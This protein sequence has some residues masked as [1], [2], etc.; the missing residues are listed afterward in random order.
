MSESIQRNVAVVLGGTNP[1]RELIRKLKRRGYH[2]VLVDYLEAPPAKVDADEHIRESTLD[3]EVVLRI[4]KEKKATLVIAACVDQANVTACY[5]GELLAL[6]IPYSHETALATTDKLMMKEGMALNGIPTTAFR[7]VQRFEEGLIKDIGF[8]MVVK[9][10]DSTG[11]KGVTKVDDEQ[12]L[13]AAID[14]AMRISRNGKVVVER[15]FEGREISVDCYVSS[16][17][18]KVIMCREKYNI[19]ERADSFI[20]CYASISPAVVTVDEES[21]ITATVQ[22][23]SKAFG[24]WNTSLL[25]Q[26]LIGA[27]GISVIEFAPRVGGGMSYQTVQMNTGFDILEATIASY[28][29]EAVEVSYHKPTKLIATNNMYARKGV[30]GEIVGDKEL[31]DEGIITQCFAYKTKG[32]SVIG[33]MASRDR[34]GAFVVVANDPEELLVKIKTAMERLDVLDIHGVS[35]MRRDI[36][37]KALD[38]QNAILLPR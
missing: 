33:D 18:V 9:P 38:G 24:L 6:P 13:R 3:K 29:G 11:S 1:H 25:V 36:Y 14:C 23:I 17:V 19:I 16:G 34:P 7:E 22:D 28:L 8:P 21:L 4:A 26:V 12:A 15:Y 20:Q 30:F 5:V 2:T 37:V 35:I 32:M 31:V 10:S 27:K